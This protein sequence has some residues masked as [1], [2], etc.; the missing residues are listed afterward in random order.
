VPASIAASTTVR[1]T[2]SDVFALLGD[3]DRHR[4][5]TD[6]GMRIVSLKGPP[7]RRTGGLVELRGPFGVTRLARTEVQGAEP[8]SR[9]WGSAETAGG[10]RAVL[11]WRVR[12]LGEGTRVEVR[13]DVHAPG[14][15]DRTL[16][17]L[18]G[19]VWLRA[20]LRAALDRLARI[21]AT[22]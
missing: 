22:R 7:G 18:G 3:L 10:A 19:R 4:E 1:A 17:R 6:R 21:V 20:R 15:R 11:E 14:W 12:P 13:L 16:L 8:R 9:L 5:L 2:G